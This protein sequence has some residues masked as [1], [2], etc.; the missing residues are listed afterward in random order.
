MNEPNMEAVTEKL[1]KALAPYPRET[2]VEALKLLAK[3]GVLDTTVTLELAKSGASKASSN[4]DVVKADIERAMAPL[5]PAARARVA[6]RMQHQYNAE[7]AKLNSN[8]RVE[9]ARAEELTRRIAAIQELRAWSPVLRLERNECS[10]LHKLKQA[11][12]TGRLISS[13]RDRHE[14]NHDEVQAPLAIQHTFVVKHDWADAFSNAEGITDEI[15]LPYDIVG[16][17]FRLS[18][19]TVII[20]AAS[21]AVLGMTAYLE[22]GEYWYVVPRGASND[23]YLAYLWSQVR[24]ICIAL[25]A[26]VATETVIRAPHKLNEKRTKAGKPPLHDYRVVDLARRHRVANPLGVPGSGS[27]KRLHFR[28]GHWRHFEAS[29]TWV[30]WCLVGDPDLGFIQKHYSL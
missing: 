22:A 14:A 17:E 30:R 4:L 29:K 25:D 20:G 24:A 7:I 8:V 1:M 12:A 15:R 2:A 18:G 13:E 9:S 6:A 5:A 3:S 23:E 16:F 28:R 11:A 21:T 26:E 27:K 19:R 10:R